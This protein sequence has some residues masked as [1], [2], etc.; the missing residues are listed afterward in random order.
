MDR[1]LARMEISYTAESSEDSNLF[2]S[3]EFLGDAEEDLL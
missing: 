2:Y 1:G 3:S